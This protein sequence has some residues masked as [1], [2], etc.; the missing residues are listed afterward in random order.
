[1]D[2]T[3]E[4][5]RLNLEV[6]LKFS[7]IEV[8]ICH[9]KSI[10][11]LFETLFAGIEKEF[12]VPFVWLTLLDSPANAPIIAAVQSSVLLKD[13]LNLITKDS[14]EHIVPGGLQPVLANKELLPY[15][16][17]LPPANKFFVKS[18]AIIPL[19]V[20][21]E[22]AG[23]WNNGDA[24]SDRYMPDMDT[25]LLQKLGQKISRRLTELVAS[26]QK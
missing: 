3:D 14:F 16:K 18:L 2:E 12:A 24:V 6:S 20:C 26:S 10:T 7:K 1:M 25:G 17:L 22:I 15:Y 21:D 4:I 13:R 11:E 19:Q 9:A 5:R 8:H 23:S